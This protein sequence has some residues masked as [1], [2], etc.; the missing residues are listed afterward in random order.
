M[1]LRNNKLS[2]KAYLKRS[3]L[4]PTMLVATFCVQSEVFAKETGNPFLLENTTT[5]SKF[6]VENSFNLNT[7]END[8]KNATDKKGKKSIK[9][10]IHNNLSN[11]DLREIEKSLAQNRNLKVK[12][13]DV[14]RNRF[15]K[16]A[17]I[18]VDVE[19]RNVHKKA[20]FQSSR[21]I[22][23]FYVGLKNTRILLEQETSE[24]E[25]KQAEN[26]DFMLLI[27]K[28]VS[29]E[30]LA[31]T[32]KKIKECFGIDVT[33]YN[34]ERESPK[35]IIKLGVRLEKDGK[36]TSSIFYSEGGIPDILIGS[37]KGKLRVVSRDSY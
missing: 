37:E 4:I 27:T 11:A 7:L 25:E 36:G 16:I 5:E 10:K 9:V 28:S 14:R 23:D 19:Y 18:N 17:K 35:K 26:L 15:N 29:D 13:W 20:M 34:K 8:D 30:N 21:G 12:F 1:T 3:I 31:K 24:Q 33:Y 32:A 6:D 2:D 22:A